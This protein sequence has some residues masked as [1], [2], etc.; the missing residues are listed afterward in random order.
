MK[1]NVF[2]EITK[3]DVLKASQENEIPT[4]IVK[5]NS[6]VFSNFIYQNFNNMIDH[7]S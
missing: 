5:E 6:D 3:L 7:G 1:E 4:K 2:K